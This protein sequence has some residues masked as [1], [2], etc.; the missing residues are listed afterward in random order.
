[1]P[2]PRIISNDVVLEAL[3]QLRRESRTPPSLRELGARVGVSAPSLYPY[4]NS[5]RDEG[6][7]TWVPGRFRTLE[8]VDG[9]DDVRTAAPG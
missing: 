3:V 8:L 2:R 1:M 5:L 4:L 9:E 6:K 7:L